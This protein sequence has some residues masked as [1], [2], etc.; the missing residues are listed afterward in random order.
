[1]NIIMKKSEN[2]LEDF[3][4]IG[5]RKNESSGSLSEESISVSSN[6]SSVSA[7]SEEIQIIMQKT[8]KIKEVIE[9]RLNAFMSISQKCYDEGLYYLEEN[10]EL[11]LLK[12]SINETVNECDKLEGKESQIFVKTV[13]DQILSLHKELS[14]LQLELVNSKT[15][16]LETEEE[17]RTLKCEIKIIEENVKKFMFEVREAENQSCRCTIL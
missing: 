10:E 12:E 16:I 1:M 17:E 14:H 5:I 4:E 7:D 3:L 15:E 6:H 13:L 11:E 9:K 8:S 2:D